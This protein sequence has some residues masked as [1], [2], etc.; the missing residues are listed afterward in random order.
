MSLKSDGSVAGIFDNS[1]FI[2]TS[3]S[4]SLLNWDLVTFTFILTS[5]GKYYSIFTAFNDQIDNSNYGFGQPPITFSSSD[6][7]HIGGPGGFLGQI[8]RFEIYSPGSQRF[9]CKQ[10]F[11]LYFDSFY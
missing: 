4:L 1:E 9:E 10:H 11:R 5:A 3:N 2:T 8:A 6:I 7:V